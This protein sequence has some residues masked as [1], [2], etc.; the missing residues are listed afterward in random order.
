M[1]DK[2]PKNGSGWKEEE[3]MGDKFSVDRCRRKKRGEIK[4]ENRMEP[5]EHTH[6]TSER[7]ERGRTAKKK[8]K[9]IQAFSS[10]ASTI[11]A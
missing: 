1:D 9:K 8:P 10:G 2:K 11:E 4:L 3:T 6:G 5:R 7:S